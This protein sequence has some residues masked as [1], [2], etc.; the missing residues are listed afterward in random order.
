MHSTKSRAVDRHINFT[1]NL[2]AP[3]EHF[4]VPFINWLHKLHNIFISASSKCTVTKLSVLLTSA[5][6]NLKQL[7]MNC[8][9]QAYERN[10]FNYFW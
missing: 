7:I 10:G 1:G 4:K 2:K 9:N 5:L 8:Y 6:S 3:G